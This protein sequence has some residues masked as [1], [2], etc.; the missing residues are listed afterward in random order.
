MKRTDDR[1]L[2]FARASRNAFLVAAMESP[3]RA[4][5]LARRA[6]GRPP[7]VYNINEIFFVVEEW[8]EMQENKYRTQRTSRMGHQ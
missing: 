2:Q 8:L 1:M 3:S 6:T 4:A 7:H 5:D